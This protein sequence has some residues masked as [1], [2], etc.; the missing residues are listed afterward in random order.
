MPNHASPCL[1][2]G[3]MGFSPSLVPCLM[4]GPPGHATPAQHV[5]PLRHVLAPPA[6]APQRDKVPSPAQGGHSSRA[7]TGMVFGVCRA[8]SKEG[9]MPCAASLPKRRSEPL[10]DFLFTEVA[11]RGGSLSCGNPPSPAQQGSLKPSTFH[12]QRRCT[13]QCQGQWSESPSAGRLPA[14][15]RPLGPTG[16]GP[17]AFPGFLRAGP[18]AGAGRER[19]PWLPASPSTPG[20]VLFPFGKGLLLHRHRR[21]TLPQQLLA[22][23]PAWGRGGA[24]GKMNLRG[25]GMGKGMRPCRRVQPRA[26]RRREARTD[27]G[28]NVSCLLTGWSR[29]GRLQRLASC[30]K[31]R[32]CPG[33]HRT[34]RTTMGA[35]RG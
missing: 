7:V 5:Q 3:T 14:K 33:G 30:S 32:E 9:G 23:L 16:L 19:W 18:G 8:V 22:P 6:P 1:S 25:K 34:S 17:P 13:A 24:A 35:A 31:H 11:E 29:P 21:E 4:L 28:D 20:P 10:V 15:L 26:P 2:I 27:L 12:P